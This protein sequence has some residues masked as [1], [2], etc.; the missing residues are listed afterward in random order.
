[1]KN[2]STR[3]MRQMVV[4]QI[5]KGRAEYQAGGDPHIEVFGPDGKS[6]YINLLNEQQSLPQ[7]D[8]QFN[9][10]PTSCYGSVLSFEEVVDIVKAERQYQASKYNEQPQS[11][12]GFLLILQKEIEE[13]IDGWMK[14]VNTGRDSPLNEVVQIAATA[15]ACIERYGATGITTNTNDEPQYR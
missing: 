1:M 2:K 12:P 13:A 5:T 3:I 8:N 14:G 6:G 4:D 9:T 15:V 11:L 10:L 7:L